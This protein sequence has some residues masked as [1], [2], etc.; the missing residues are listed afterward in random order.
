MVLYIE[1]DSQKAIILGKGGQRIKQIGA[2]A[3]TELEE[4]MERRV[5]S[6]P[7]CQGA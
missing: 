2:A 7:A 4:M 6:A 3:R 1:R 5:H